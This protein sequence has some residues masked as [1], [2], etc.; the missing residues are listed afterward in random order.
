MYYKKA[1]FNDEIRLEAVT[2]GSWGNK[3][4]VTIDYNTKDKNDATPVLF[5]ITITEENGA[6]EKFLDISTDK[7]Q[8]SYLPRCA[9]AV[10]VAQ[11]V[12]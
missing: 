6:I 3:I 9:V 7:T 1:N 12:T 11:V 8:P 10:F 4:S 5:N 2:A